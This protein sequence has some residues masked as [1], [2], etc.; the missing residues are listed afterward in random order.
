MLVLVAIVASAICLVLGLM[1]GP[2]LLVWIALGLSLAGLV[3]IML[4]RL[5]RPST[6]AGGQGPTGVDETERS[7]TAATGTEPN[8]D[9]SDDVA[10]DVTPAEQ[11]SSPGPDHDSPEAA[12]EPMPDSEQGAPGDWTVSESS[13]ATHGSVLPTGS[14]L[15]TD[16]ATDTGDEVSDGAPQES[17]DKSGGPGATE[18]DTVLVVHGRRRFHRSGCR[19][20]ESRTTEKV[21]VDEALEEGFT[22]CSTCIP[23]RSAVAAG[24]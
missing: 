1:T 12:T 14:E 9:G 16:A 3:L 19:L 22:P 21:H 2:F 17:G 13:V 11:S 8:D 5:S 18:L 24:S 4:P 10:R 7:G 23:D 20:L 15:P 6:G